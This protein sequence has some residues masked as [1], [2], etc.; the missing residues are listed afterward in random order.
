MEIVDKLIDLRI[1]LSKVC[2]GLV[3]NQNAKSNMLS[4][5]LKILHILSVNDAT[6]GELI[7]TLCVAKG[8]LA[9][10]LKNMIE[11]GV[12]ES[13]KN[14]ENSKNIYYRVTSKGLKEIQEYKDSISHQIEKFDLGEM[15]L[16]KKIDE[17][18]QILKGY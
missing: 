1:Y 11:N 3:D 13:Y 5:R 12:V 4:T 8:N 14:I 15:E 17:I 18:I 10:L 6:P 7:S 16:S 9:N 2:D